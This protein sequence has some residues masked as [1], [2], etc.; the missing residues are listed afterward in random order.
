MGI[1]D[2]LEDT[3]QRTLSYFDLSTLDL[4]KNRG[5][6]TWSVRW[7]L[8]HLADAETVLY[9]RIRRTLAEPRPVLWAFDQD[10]WAKGL[11]YDGIP[12]SVSRGI[13][14]ATRD[15]VIHQAR[16]HYERSGSREYVHS[17]TGVRTL[18]EEF[19]KVAWHNE[20]HLQQIA[21]ALQR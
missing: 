4:A 5:A 1:I 17:E 9:D 6:G 19:D 12:L 13:F 2:Q 10:A 11:D 15:G 20:R 21:E 16:A 3:R 18:R 8:H 14:A 7:I